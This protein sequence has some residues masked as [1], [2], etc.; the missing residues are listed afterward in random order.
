MEQA[1]G[2]NAGFLISS[3][4]LIIIIIALFVGA[5][6]IWKLREDRLKQQHAVAVVDA[7][8]EE[9]EKLTSSNRIDP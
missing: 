4:I 5:Y 6:Q 8:N 7:S 1:T 2:G 9:A 3:G